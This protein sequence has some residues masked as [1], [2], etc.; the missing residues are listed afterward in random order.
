MNETSVDGGF[1]HGDGLK[2]LKNPSALGNGGRS[3][4]RSPEVSRA[5]QWCLW[6][7]GPVDMGS[8]VIGGSLATD[9]PSLGRNYLRG[10]F[11]FPLLFFVFFWKRTYRLSGI[12]S[13][14]SGTSASELK[15]SR[16]NSFWPYF[17]FIF[18][19]EAYRRTIA[20]GRSS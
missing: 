5:T 19:M 14:G 1:I 13:G 10:I 15:A 18:L 17:V 3:C 16:E 7:D 6:C 11:A 20:D 8:L 12:F 2:A 4:L 9:S